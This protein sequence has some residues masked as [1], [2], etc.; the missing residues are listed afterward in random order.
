MNRYL[1]PLQWKVGISFV[2]LQGGEEGSGGQTRHYRVYASHELH[3]LV[4]THNGKGLVDSYEEKP[5][6]AAHPQ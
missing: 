2:G 4:F 5:K 6:V 3:W 1:G